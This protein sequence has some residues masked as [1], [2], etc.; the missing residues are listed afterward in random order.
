MDEQAAHRKEGSQNPKRS[1]L[2][3]FL[4]VNCKTNKYGMDYYCITCCSYSY[5]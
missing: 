1:L 3:A 4:G 5:A 2:F